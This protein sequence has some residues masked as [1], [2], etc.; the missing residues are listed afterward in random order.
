MSKHIL[1]GFLFVFCLH[2]SFAQKQPL[3]SIHKSPKKAALLS[4]V[5]PGAGQIYNHYPAKGK[6]A[7]WKLPIIY[8]GL[9][10]SIYFIAN[11]NKNYKNFRNA[12]LSIIND[13]TGL[14]KTATVDGREYTSTQ[15]R[16]ALDQYRS[17]RDL[18]I[19]ITAGIYA[20]QIIDA[21]VDAHLFRHDVSPDLSLG[22]VP[23]YRWNP[24]LGSGT[25]GIQLSLRFK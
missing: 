5:F 12:Y 25:M 10:T 21:S 19:V 6:R 17:W 20:L 23:D 4:A 18:S 1:L 2:C 3:D 24:V 8:G 7:L 14:I 16:A 15:S 13:T 22:V 9:G 11:N